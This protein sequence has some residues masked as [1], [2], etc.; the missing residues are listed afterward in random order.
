MPGRCSLVILALFAPALRAAEGGGAF[1]DRVRA[2]VGGAA[3]AL[4]DIPA[5]SI[6]G[7]IDLRIL[8][9][10][11]TPAHGDSRPPR[12]PYRLA[13]RIHVNTR[14]SVLERELL[15]GSGDPFD[16]RT[17]EESERRLRQHST[18][19][20]AC[21]A[22]VRVRG[23]EVDVMVVTRDVWTLGARAGFR[24]SGEATTVQFG[25]EDA[26]FLGSGRLVDLAYVDDPDRTERRLRYQD[27]ALFG[28]RA[29][30]ALKVAE[31][32]DGHRYTLDA[33]RPFFS[34]DA[35]WS[36]GTRL[37]SD[38]A[39]IK[40]YSRGEV[41]DRFVQESTFLEVRGGLSPGYTGSGAHRFLAGFTWDERRFHDAP[42]GLDPLAPPGPFGPAELG[43]GGRLG[44]GG[45]A[46]GPSAGPLTRRRLDSPRERAEGPRSSTPT[47]G[48]R[49]VAYPWVGWQW[50]EDGFVE[51]HDMDRLARTEDWNLGA[52]WSA[53]AGWSSAAWG[54][55]SDQAILSL[56]W[57]QGAAT[58]RG[59][60]VVLFG[61]WGEGRFDTDSTENLV[62]GARVR[63]YFSNFGRHQLTTSVQL[64]AARNLDP[65]T[66]LLL[67]GDNGLRGYPMRFRDGDRRLLASVEQR[68]YTDLEVLDLFHVGAAVFVDAGRAWYAG[69]RPGEADETL[70]DIGVGLRLGSS[71][72]SQGTMIHLDVAF[73]LDGRSGERRGVQ[74]LVTTKESF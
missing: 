3:V 38:Q 42:A 23:R 8:D 48:S 51:R 1:C 19:Y 6:V 71:R 57:R 11:D 47:P 68:F 45:A 32:S 64:D 18:V 4:A 14:P 15:F 10:F 65:E 55:D 74:W 54:A 35:R 16:P 20:D 66:Q 49:T 12:L 52:Q 62:A 73:P 60:H 13:N 61:A 17:L 69:T 29:E 53:R 63:H 26:N 21:I 36:A 44:P 9:V 22:P 40:L 7:R 46:P 67:G 72:S 50:V 28:T 25:L 59:R 31:R 34:F 24:R 41:T 58:R 30:L 2:Q 33:E 27:P 70:R 56:D 39:L 37:V 5:G 43:P